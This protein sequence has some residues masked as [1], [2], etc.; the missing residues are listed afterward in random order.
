MN[1]A[2]H[3]GQ[4]RP[5]PQT[6]K[7]F[8]EQHLRSLEVVVP[9]VEAQPSLYM[10]LPRTLFSRETIALAIKSSNVKHKDAERDDA[11]APYRAPGPQR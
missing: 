3:S 5:S 1:L 9:H 4:I 8:T 7:V 2:P 11:I 6:A 10:D